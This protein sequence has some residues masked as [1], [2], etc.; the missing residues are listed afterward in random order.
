MVRQIKSWLFAGME[1]SAS[2]FSPTSSARATA[3]TYSKSRIPQEGSVF[4]KDL[5][6]RSLRSLVKLTYAG[7][8]EPMAYR[9]V[10]ANRAR[11]P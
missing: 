7:M 8:A 2:N 1:W 9:R 5:S 11:R 3:S 6:V 4:F 10:I